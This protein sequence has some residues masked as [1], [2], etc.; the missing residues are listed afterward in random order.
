MSATRDRK[1]GIMK[2]I[3][4]TMAVLAI[5]STPLFAGSGNAEEALYN[6]PDKSWRG[7]ADR[8][9]GCTW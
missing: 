4:L 8:S 6:L 9:A 2:L 3:K 1:A 7:M 5:A